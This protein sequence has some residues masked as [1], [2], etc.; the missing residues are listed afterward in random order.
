M[1]SVFKCEALA[2]KAKCCSTLRSKA[3]LEH[4]CEMQTKRRHG[5]K[6]EHHPLRRSYTPTIRSTMTEGSFSLTLSARRHENL[7]QT[8]IVRSP[9][10][11]AK[12][13]SRAFFGSHRLA[14]PLLGPQA[15]QVH[16]TRQ[17]AP[18][19]SKARALRDLCGCARPILNPPSMFR[20]W[21]GTDTVGSEKVHS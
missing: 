16:E 15:R 20:G 6:D 12:L 9:Q 14:V 7:S 11:G 8:K 18:R 17:D 19:K 4:C 10:F 2:Q 1:P 13:L 5:A 3:Q 21:L